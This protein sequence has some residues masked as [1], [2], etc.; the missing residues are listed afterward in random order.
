MD[1]REVFERPRHPYAQ[2]LLSAV[3]LPDPGVERRRTR[4]LLAGDP[5]SPTRRHT[6]CHFPRP[7]TVLTAEA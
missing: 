3:P 2:A 4:V 5:P 7:R 6:G 1:F